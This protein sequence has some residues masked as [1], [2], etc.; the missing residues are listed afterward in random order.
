MGPGR[1]LVLTEE[2]SDAICQGSTGVNI[3]IS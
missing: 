2:L 1:Y 3:N